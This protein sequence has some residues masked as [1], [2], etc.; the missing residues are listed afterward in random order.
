M[1]AVSKLAIFYYFYTD[2][3]SFLCWSNSMDLHD[4]RN[5]DIV[6]SLQAV[7]DI[8]RFKTI[9]LLVQITQVM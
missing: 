4:C 2:K 8:T 1:F 6:Q 5:V 7:N 3:L 9:Y